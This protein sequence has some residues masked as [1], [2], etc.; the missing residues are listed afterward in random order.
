MRFGLRVGLGMNLHLRLVKASARTHFT[1]VS[2]TK[3]KQ[4][5]TEIEICELY[6]SMCKA[7]AFVLNERV[8]C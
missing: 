7:F 2:N 6:I 3:N 8:I 5:V 4:L 1:P